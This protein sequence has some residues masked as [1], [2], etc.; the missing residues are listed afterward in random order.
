MPDEVVEQGR[1]IGGMADGCGDDE[2]HPPAGFQ[3][4][5]GR[6]EERRPGPGEP[7]E[8]RAQAGAQ[9]EGALAHLA[10][11]GLVANEGRIARGAFEALAGPCGPGEEIALV[12]AGPGSAAHRHGRGL[13]VLL[14]AEAVPVGGDEAPVS[15]GGVEKPVAV[16]PDRPPHEVRNDGVGRVVGAGLFSREAGHRGAPHRIGVSH[17]FVAANGNNANHIG[18]RAHSGPGPWCNH[19]C[20]QCFRK[21]LKTGENKRQVLECTKESGIPLPGARSISPPRPARHPDRLRQRRQCVRRQTMQ[22]LRT[23]L[24]LHT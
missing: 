7:R 8:L 17:P 11:E 18:T 10:L 14:D 2:R 1:G 23:V 22:I 4:A 12:D 20:R 16:F 15:A 9:L 13:G 21:R 24:D 6:H 19:P 5:R 3:Q